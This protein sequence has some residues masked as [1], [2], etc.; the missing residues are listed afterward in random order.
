VEPFLI[1]YGKSI[2]NPEQAGYGNFLVLLNYLWFYLIIVE[3]L[4]NRYNAFTFVKWIYLFGFLMVIPFGIG[5]QRSNLGG[6][7]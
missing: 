2:V 1:L 5:I 6:V 4:M 7:H 3:K